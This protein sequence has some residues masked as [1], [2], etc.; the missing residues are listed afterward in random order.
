MSGISN[1]TTLIGRIGNDP[2]LEVKDGKTM[3]TFTLYV[4]E[5]EMNRETKRF[6]NFSTR[7]DLILWNQTAESLSK[8]LTKGLLIAVEGRLKHKEKL[9][10][11]RKHRELIFVI[12]DVNP[13]MGTNKKE[14][15][16]HKHSESHDLDD[17]NH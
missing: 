9:V 11:G 2:Q 3:L 4:S 15:N 6:E 7:F 10:D 5:R 1:R 12:Q 13:F 8:I 17:E 14:T 16:D